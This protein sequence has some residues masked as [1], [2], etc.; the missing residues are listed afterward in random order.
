MTT[1]LTTMFADFVAGAKSMAW[2]FSVLI[3]L[4]V[5]AFNFYLPDPQP[6]KQA[7]YEVVAIGS[8]LYFKVDIAHDATYGAELVL[9][10]GNDYLGSLPI[11]QVGH[12]VTTATYN[13]PPS[14]TKQKKLKLNVYWTINHWTQLVSPIDAFKRLEVTN[15]K[16]INNSSSSNS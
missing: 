4:A 7:E 10:I 5:G 13:L 8:K 2:N 16:P 6:I 9:Y 15:A 1:R 11:P 12:R 3:G 14:A